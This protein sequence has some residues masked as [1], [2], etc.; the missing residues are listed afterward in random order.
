MKNF[1]NHLLLIFSIFFLSSCGFTPMYKLQS[2]N[3]HIAEVNTSIENNEYY[4]F[5]EFIKPYMINKKNDVSYNL[6]I[7]LEKSKNIISKDSSGNPLAYVM[8]VKAKV[9]INSNENLLISKSYKK[10]FKYSRNSSIFD[11]N[12]YEKKLEE[13]LIKKIVDEII[14]SIISLNKNGSTSKKN[15]I[16]NIKIKGNSEVGYGASG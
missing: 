3:F 16:N 12:L 14:N 6:T 4:I 10:K 5:K 13:N 15:K 7:S 1:T 2:T 8:I 11:L 9:F